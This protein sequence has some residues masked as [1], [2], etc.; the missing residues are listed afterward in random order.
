M[1]KS[2]KPVI[3]VC[4]VRTGSGKS[5]TT[6]KIA[7]ILKQ[8]DY[9]VVAIRH[10]M[11][12]GNLIRQEVQ[13]FQKYDDLEK[14]SCTIE[15]R[16]EYEPLIRKGIIVYAGVDYEKILRRAEKEADVIIFDGGNNDFPFIKP[17]LHIVVADPLRPGHEITYHPGE[18]N[19]RMADV[20]IINK[21]DSARREDVES[22]IS[23]ARNANPK[24]DIIKAR[25]KIIVTSSAIIRGRKALVVEDGPTLTHGGMRFGAGSV[26]AKRF[27]A[28]KII[29]ARKH[30]VGSIKAVYAQYPHLKNILPAMG[31]SRNQ[32]RELEL[33]INRSDCD[34]VIDGTPID[35][36]KLLKIKKPIAVV[37]YELDDFGSPNIKTM[38]GR[39]ETKFL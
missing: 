12:Y 26:A 35:M 32:I 37:D 21:I 29:D 9:K 34:V 28:A 30:A 38:L 16:E 6:R 14:Q 11:P 10:P 8:K 2:R 33:T 18:T 31:Y 5:Q 27:K 24:A 23:N 36:S 22:V 17:D 25:S 3:A 15:E 7:M 4:A 20:I 39:F 13:R 19:L 1:L